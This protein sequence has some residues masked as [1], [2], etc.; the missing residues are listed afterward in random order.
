MKHSVPKSYVKCVADQV[1]CLDWC[2]GNHFC[3]LTH[4]ISEEAWGRRCSTRETGTGSKH[5]SA[6]KSFIWETLNIYGNRTWGWRSTFAGGKSSLMKQGWKG[7]PQR[8][9]SKQG[10]DSKRHLSRPL[11][12]DSTESLTNSVEKF[13]LLQQ[14]RNTL[15][16]HLKSSQWLN[17]REILPY[18][19]S[20]KIKENVTRTHKIS[21]R[22]SPKTKVNSL[23]LSFGD[24]LASRL[25]S[26]VI[27]LEACVCYWLFNKAV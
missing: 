1:L 9:L 15:S 8:S 6:S 22:F 13:T 12:S 24:E 27:I 17:V 23:G 11:N 14:L 3:H 25:H 16:Q 4:R 26:Y 10:T 18:R 2:S 19:E 20:A 5:C 21:N 7:V